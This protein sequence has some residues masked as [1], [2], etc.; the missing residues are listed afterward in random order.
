MKHRL[1]LSL[2][3][4]IL[5]IGIIVW[6][7]SI[8]TAD[9]V[10]IPQTATLTPIGEIARDRTVRQQLPMPGSAITTLSLYL[11]TYQR[12]MLWSLSVRIEVLDSA[13]TWT[14]IATH[15]IEPAQIVDNAYHTIR[16][17]PALA[18]P[19]ARGL[20]VSLSSEAPLGEAATWWGTPLWTRLGYQLTLN[21][22]PVTGNAIM[23]LQYEHIRGPL[24]LTSPFIWHRI[25]AFL[26]PSLQVV[27]LL[28]L[29]C[30]IIATAIT[31]RRTTSNRLM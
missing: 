23:T 31:L 10:L 8:K 18:L 15:T 24:L 1:L 21:D 4:W 3:L 13:G 5:L 29:C 11:A 26:N 6:P 2:L 27:L 19:P 7:M 25:T 16:F 28:S 20:A 22:Q 12:T 14:T 9:D 17:S 30:G